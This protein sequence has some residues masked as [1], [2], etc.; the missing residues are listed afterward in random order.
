[1][2]DSYK[3]DIQRYLGMAI[4]FMYYYNSDLTGET[5]FYDDICKNI[6]M[7]LDVHFNDIKMHLKYGIDNFEE[8]YSQLDHPFLEQYTKEEV[9]TFFQLFYNQLVKCESNL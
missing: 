8:C 4:H 2:S 9:S 7:D 3:Y 5:K 1:M 6:K